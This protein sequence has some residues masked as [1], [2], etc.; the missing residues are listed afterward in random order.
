MTIAW[1][2]DFYTSKEII[3]D[4]LKYLFKELP[5]TIYIYFYKDKNYKNL[6][7]Q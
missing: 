4:A 1:K 3:R 7:I 2:F 5:N 6:N